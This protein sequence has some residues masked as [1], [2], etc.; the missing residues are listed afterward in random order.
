[1]TGEICF[2][3]SSILCR[4][5]SGLNCKLRHGI[6]AV[7]MLDRAQSKSSPAARVPESRYVFI[8]QGMQAHAEVIGISSLVPATQ[9]LLVDWTPH[10]SRAVIRG[11]DKHIVTHPHVFKCIV[12]C[13]N[14]V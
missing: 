10:Q 6:G 3:L 12:K 1:M 14:M 2:L 8:L 11:L 7:E 4:I 13:G 5:A 9:C